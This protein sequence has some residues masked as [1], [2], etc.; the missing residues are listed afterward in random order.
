MICKNCGNPLEENA[1][2]CG[3]CGTKAD[4]IAEEPNGIVCPFCG[5]LTEEGSVF[6]EV[7]GNRIGEKS[8]PKTPVV[9]PEKRN[10][11]LAL[12]VTVA[13]VA[14]IAVAM[15]CV[16]IFGNSD[17][18][19]KSPKRETHI[20]EQT[21]KPK[22]K[23]KDDEKED[24]QKAYKLEKETADEMSED[25]LFPSDKKH[26]TLSDLEGRSKEEVALIRNEIYARHGYIF[27]TEAYNRYFMTK[28]WYTP[29]PNFNET[30]FS[31]IELRNKDFIVEYEKSKGWR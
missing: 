31:E 19:S 21:E 11:N 12:Y 27:T 18:N 7:C 20:E 9:R 10:S 14:V 29:N 30:M 28:E 24:T 25:Y 17:S 5:K 23:N 2:F 6:C 1:L 16:F 8:T 26:I 13:F 22:Q 4:G 3:N 15:A